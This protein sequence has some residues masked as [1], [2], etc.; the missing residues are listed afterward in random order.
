MLLQSKYNIIM[1]HKKVLRIMTKYELLSKVRKR[2]PYKQIQ[3]ATKEH[4]S[5]SNILNRNFKWIE[6]FSKFWT[7]ISYLYYNWTKAY[8]YIL[9]DMVTWEIISHKLSSNLWLNFVIQ[10]IESWKNILKKM[11]YNSI[12]SM[13]SLYSSLIPKII[14][15][16]L[17]YSIYV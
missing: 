5:L 14:K 10:T 7:D 2:N 12:R 3:K 13:I 16:K 1:N 9:K 8:I 11:K 4:N 17:N 6:V 15:R